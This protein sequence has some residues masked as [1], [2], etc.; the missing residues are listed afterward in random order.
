MESRKDA[1]QEF[2]EKLVSA[3]LS[4]NVGAAQVPNMLTSTVPMSVMDLPFLCCNFCQTS[5]SADR[6]CVDMAI[7]ACSADSY[8]LQAS[9]LK[10]Q[11]RV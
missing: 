3:P 8:V 2:K 1:E 10:R 7:L 6:R 4:L 5:S 9:A 11:W